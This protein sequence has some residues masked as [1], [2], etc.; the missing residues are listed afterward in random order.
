MEI[1]FIKKDLA[2][3]A[4]TTILYHYVQYVL[5]YLE[6]IDIRRSRRITEILTE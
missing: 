2:Y 5:N 4:I 3:K 6:A 1:V